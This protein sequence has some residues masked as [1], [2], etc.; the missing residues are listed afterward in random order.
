[1][2]RVRIEKALALLRTTDEPIKAIA[3]GLRFPDLPHFYREFRPL[4]TRAMLKR[5]DLEPEGRA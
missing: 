1:M 2:S 4:R 3:E 5:H